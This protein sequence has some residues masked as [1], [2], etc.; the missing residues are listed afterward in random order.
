MAALQYADV[1]GYKA[2]LLRKTYPELS[3]ASGLI[4]RSKEWLLGKARWNEQLHRWTFASGA[5]LEFGHLHRS[6]DRSSYQGSEFDFIGFDELTHFEELDYTY[7][8]SRL[9]RREGSQIPP[10]M[11]AATN[12]GGRGHRWVKE[13]FIDQ[14]APSRRFVPARLA[15]NPGI[16]HA[17]YLAALQELDPQTRAQLLDGDWNAREPGSW[18]YEQ[19]GIDA[20][21][22]LGRDFDAYRH[23]G[24]L[25]PPAGSAIQLGI[26][27]GIGTTHSLVIWPLEGG[28]V[29]IP[30]GEVVVAR[31]EPGRLTEAMLKAAEPYDYL[32]DEARYDAAG[33]QQMATFAAVAPEEVSIFRVDFNKRKERTIGF[34][35][36]LFRRTA[37]GET[38]RIIAISPENDVLLDQLRGLKLN[39]LGRVVKEAD[40]GP[41][42]LIAGVWPIAAEF[43]DLSAVG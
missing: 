36:A 11:R 14:A 29:Y 33:A 42:A 20:A 13:R 40:H 6:T 34:L 2:L 30:P 26:D 41:D 43:P 22:R 5:I 1:P 39:E 16:D 15:D 23:D 31:G 38:T 3:Q 12:P 9:R 35:R 25:A 18:V 37:E 10:R 17:A 24:T 19:V 32:L 28:G 4:D 7:L 8:F 21:E 27:W